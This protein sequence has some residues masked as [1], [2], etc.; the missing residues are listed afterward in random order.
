M[1]YVGVWLDSKYLIVA[2]TQMHISYI[3][4]KTDEYELGIAK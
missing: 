3:Q 1:S 2:M 4:G